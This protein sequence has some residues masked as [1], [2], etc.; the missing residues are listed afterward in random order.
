MRNDHISA[1]A[2]AKSASPEPILAAG[3][4]SSYGTV[5]SLLVMEVDVETPDD[6]DVVWSL[7]SNSFFVGGGLLYVFASSWDM[8][9][10]PTEE[11]GTSAW[12]W[13]WYNL[14]WLLGS[15]V[16]LLNAVI[17][18]LW[19]LRDKERQKQRR[20]LKQQ[21]NQFKQEEQQKEKRTTTATFLKN[22]KAQIKNLWR[23]VRRHVGHRRELSAALTFG[24]AAAFGLVASLLCFNSRISEAT[25]NSFDGLSVHFYLLSAFFALCGRRPKPTT[26]SSSSGT[27]NQF[28]F[29]CFKFLSNADQ[30]E[31]LGDAFFGIGSL[32]DVILCDMHFD[33]GLAY[34][35]V[36]SSAL[37]LLDAL[38]Y[39]RSDF[40]TL[41][42]SVNG[43]DWDSGEGT[44]GTDDDEILSTISTL[45]SSTPTAPAF[46][47]Y[48][49]FA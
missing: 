23:R 13:F 16:Y 42:T 27:T 47:G 3:E 20:L 2:T 26:D 36:I 40:C 22:R 37:W 48:M 28:W 7:A 11:D 18:V 35:P 45:S 24:I 32:V 39:L 29:P 38:L 19:A 17:D 6:D 49:L 21:Y 31:D 25:V 34:W 8:Y 41:Y 43:K 10:P 5:S 46:G 15:L 33:D 44:M 14:V 1:T 30:L 4:P 9:D 12:T